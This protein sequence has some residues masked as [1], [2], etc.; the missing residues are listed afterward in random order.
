MRHED[1]VRAFRHLERFT[2]S[3]VKAGTE[4]PQS[5]DEIRF[6]RLGAEVELIRARAVAANR[7]AP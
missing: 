7:P 6:W 1:Q 4:P 2:D 3:R 5:L